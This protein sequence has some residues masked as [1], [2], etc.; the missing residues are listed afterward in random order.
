MLT[1]IL[2]LSCILKCCYF[3]DA[4]KTQE[5]QVLGAKKVEKL[6]IYCT[7][8]RKVYYLLSVLPVLLIIIDNI[9]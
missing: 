3:S 8:V 4:T 6:W 9:R 2:V 5:F 7:E 1:I